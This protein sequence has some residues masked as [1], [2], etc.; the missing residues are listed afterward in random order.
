MKKRLSVIFTAMYLMIMTNLLY[1]MHQLNMGCT[2]KYCLG[3]TLNE[4]RT[5]N[6]SKTPSPSMVRIKNEP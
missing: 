2:S 4:M 1:K 6:T 5:Y 3:Y